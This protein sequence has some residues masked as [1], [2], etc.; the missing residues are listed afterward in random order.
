[1]KMKA[2]QIIGFTV[3]FGMIG[4]CALDKQARTP[5]EMGQQEDRMR[6]AL[7]DTSPRNMTD[8]PKVTPEFSENFVTNGRKTVVEDVE[9]P[10]L[11][12]MKGSR[13]EAEAAM[14]E[15]Y[16][17]KAKAKAKSKGKTK[18][19]SKTQAKAKAKSATKDLTAKA[20]DKTKTLAKAKAK[21]KV[22]SATQSLTARAK[23][24]AIAKSDAKSKP[25]KK[26]K[27][28]VAE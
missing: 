1:M 7:T 18:S 16:E 2:L 28:A 14:A 11:I 27:S 12:E 5:E 3:V 8:L 17:P 10:A 23:G 4:G 25:K 20:K 21:S 26:A 22:K 15:E 6:Q 13:K 9:E 19:K 24:K